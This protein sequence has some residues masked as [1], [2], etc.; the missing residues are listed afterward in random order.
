MPRGGKREGAGRP[1]GGSQSQGKSKQI[2]VVLDQPQEEALK[3]MAARTGKSLAEVI[4]RTL[5]AGLDALQKTS[6]PPPT[7]K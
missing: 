7:G 5:D 1:K 2:K 3:A 4:R 6:T